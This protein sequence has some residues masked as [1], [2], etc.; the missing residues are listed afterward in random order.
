MVDNK[1]NEPN[2]D[3]EKKIAIEYMFFCYARRL[4]TL[5]VPQKECHHRLIENR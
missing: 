4:G 1:Q 3:E 2:H 5:A